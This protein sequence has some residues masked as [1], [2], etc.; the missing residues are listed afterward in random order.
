MIQRGKDNENHWSSWG[1]LGV[2]EGHAWKL[3]WQQRSGIFAIS[4]LGDQSELLS[5]TSLHIS[6]KPSSVVTARQRSLLQLQGVRQNVICPNYEFVES[7]FIS[8]HLLEA[9]DKHISTSKWI[10]SFKVTNMVGF[11]FT[12]RIWKKIQQKL[13]QAFSIIDTWLCR[14][15][16]GG[17]PVFYTCSMITDAH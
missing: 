12:F 1:I 16:S 4:H 6:L 14:F 2:T 9:Y 11:F 3:L 8:S 10:W 5:R 17:W 7:T 13:E 15:N